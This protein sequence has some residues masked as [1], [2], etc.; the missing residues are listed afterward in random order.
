MSVY[1]HEMKNLPVSHP[2]VFERL[3]ADEFVVHLRNTL[4][5]SPIA[6][7][8]AIEVTCNRD[9]KTNGGINGFSQNVAALQ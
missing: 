3:S 4:S 7:D 2:S 8:Q 5:F 6:C 9:S 1:L